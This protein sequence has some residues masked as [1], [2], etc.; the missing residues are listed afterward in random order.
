MSGYQ[1]RIQGADRL[2]RIR[3]MRRLVYTALLVLTVLLMYARILGEG[4]S[5]KPIFVPLDGILEIGLIMGLIATLLG[6][7]LRNLEIQSAQRDSQRYLM[8]KYSMSRAAT[9]AL[10]ALVVGALLVLPVTAS[11]LP[12]AI[13]EPTRAAS[14][15]P[16]ETEVVNLTTPDAFGVSYVREVAVHSSSGSV[17]VQ[18]VRDSAI[19]ASGTVT[20]T[21]PL[22]LPVESNGWTSLS[23][24]SVRFVNSGSVNAMVAYSFPLG[25]MPSYFSTLPF[26]LFLLVAA[27]V[28]WWFGLRPIRNRTKT[29]ALYAS[30]EAAAV[31]DMGERQYIEYA[32]Q[33]PPPVRPMAVAADPPPPP[34][35]VAPPPPPASAP[36]PAVPVVVAAPTP[37]SLP[38]VDTAGSLAAKGDTLAAISEYGSAVAAYDESLRLEPDRI[39]VLLSKAHALGAMGSRDAAL[40]AY[41]RVLALDASNDTALRESAKL[42]ASRA[43]WR[44]CLET[45]EILLRR[46]PND[47][48]G[49]QL[50]GDVLTNLGRRPEALAAYEAA[51]ALDPSDANLKQK[52]EEVRV[53]VPGLLS[54]ALI[55]SASGNYAQ[56]LALFDDILEVEPGNVNA[57]IGK[58]VAYRRSGRPNE[59]LNCLDLVL[60]FQPNNA[61][62]LLNRGTLLLERDDVDGALEVFNRLVTISP[63]DEEAWVAQ[64]DTLVR[65]GREDDAL[66][67]YREALRLNPGDEETQHK[68]GELE[69]RRS[70]GGDVLQ[71]LYRVKGVGPARAKA[72]LEAGFRSAEDYRQATLEQLLAVKGITHRIAEDLLK[73][74]RTAVAVSAS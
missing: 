46:R 20:E 34:P 27:N 56:A 67:A 63:Q 50:K 74:F 52:I 21:A 60:H 51:A 23:N 13:T 16:G 43:R 35:A 2:L 17:E 72:L 7:Y 8:S 48:A 25:I 4:A 28:G 61:S 9:T 54:R 49:L 22:E 57:L 44:E 36:S 39:P 3:R 5:L 11:A 38:S 65:K 69:A 24:W 33:S 58:A 55:A 73:H 12:A 68:V 29:A 71:E 14:I 19:Q 70:V 10:A 40:D 26:L 62:A 31:V 15:A 64:A 37:V 59:A 45:V 53:D 30:S 18:V 32:L 6:L 41:R 42:L 66:H 47:V 1:L